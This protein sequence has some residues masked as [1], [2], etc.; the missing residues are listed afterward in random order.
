[1]SEIQYKKIG[2]CPNCGREFVRPA[3]VTHAACDC[4]S[5]VLVPLRP[6]VLL[7]PRTFNRFQKIADRAGVNVEV[8]VNAILEV[9]IEKIK[10]MSIEEVL[11]LE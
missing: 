2:I 10:G 5:A 7:P 6:V 4:K 3:E 1:M 8:L 11:A 9:G